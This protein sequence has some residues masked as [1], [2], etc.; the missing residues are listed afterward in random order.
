MFIFAPHAYRNLCFARFAALKPKSIDCDQI[1]VFVA[2]SAARSHCKIGVGAA[3]NFEIVWP[4]LT[5]IFA[6][7]GA[8]R[9]ATTRHVLCDSALLVFA[10]AVVEAISTRARNKPKCGER[11]GD[12]AQLQ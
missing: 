3:A 2:A 1:A 8:D 4:P 10:V 5:K 6:H 7:R 9:L 12:D 11:G